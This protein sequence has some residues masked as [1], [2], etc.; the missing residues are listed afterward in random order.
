MQLCLDQ[1][2]RRA[3]WSDV[4]DAAEELA[5]SSVL[6]CSIQADLEDMYRWGGAAATR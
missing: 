1:A 2:A 4:S 5:H 6:L 3:A